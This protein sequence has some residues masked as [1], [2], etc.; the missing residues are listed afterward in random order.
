MGLKYPRLVSSMEFS[1]FSQSDAEVMAVYPAG[2]V[3]FTPFGIIKYK[4]C[5]HIICLAAVGVCPDA[6]FHHK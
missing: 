5:R 6:G 3:S 4:A 1:T 2:H